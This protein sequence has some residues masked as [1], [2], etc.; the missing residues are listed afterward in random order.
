MKKLKPAEV[1]TIEEKARI[2]RLQ[3]YAKID[4]MT[5]RMMESDEMRERQIESDL[6][7]KVLTEKS[8][9]ARAE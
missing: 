3:D 4:S 1:M 9:L 7:L 8:A 6:K 5:A 2:S